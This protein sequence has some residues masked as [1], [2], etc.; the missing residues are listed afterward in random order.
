MILTSGSN[1]ISFKKNCLDPI[2]LCKD[3]ILFRNLIGILG[4]LTNPSVNALK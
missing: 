4:I 3:L 1:L 2:F